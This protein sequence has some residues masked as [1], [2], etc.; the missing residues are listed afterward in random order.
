MKLAWI[1]YGVM[2]RAMVQ[3]L[4]NAGHEVHIYTRSM[5]EAGFPRGT[6]LHFH[7]SIEEA[8]AGVEFIFTMVGYPSDVEEVYFSPRG[9]VAHYNTTNEAICVDMTTS[10]PTLAKRIADV[11]P[12]SLDAPVSGGDL[13]AINAS[14]SIMVG[15]SRE[16]YEKSSILLRLMGKH[17]AHC[18]V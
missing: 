9:I 10:S 7:S 4:A 13:G 14:L 16:S 5:P 8:I 12:S 3:H 11:L 18:G 6:S 1:G 15:G 2:G 17:I